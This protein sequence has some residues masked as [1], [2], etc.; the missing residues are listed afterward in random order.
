MCTDFISFVYT[1]DKCMDKKQKRHHLSAK[2]KT[3]GGILAQVKYKTEVN[4]SAEGQ[5]GRTE[6]PRQR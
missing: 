2:A 5:T 6:K 4:Y 3:S 1:K